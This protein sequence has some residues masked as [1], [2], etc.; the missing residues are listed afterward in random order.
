MKRGQ[1]P[2][3]LAPLAH[4]DF[5]LLW[6]G[7]SFSTIGNFVATVALPW[8]VLQLTGSPAQIGIVVAIS[9]ATNVALLLLGGAVVDRLPRRR[10]LLVSDFLSALVFGVIG[11]LGQLG[12]LRIEHIYIATAISAA[13]A[14]FFTPAITALLPDL[15]PSD[16]LVA[17]NSLR[18][19]SR[20][21]GRMLGPALGGLL[22]AL[23]GL[24]AAFGF[25]AL[26]FC[27]SFLAVLATHPTDDRARPHT[28]L[29]REVRT[30]VAFVFAHGWIWVTIALAS[31]LNTFLIAATSVALP[32]ELREVL[33]VDAAAFGLV[34]AAQG[35]GEAAGALITN[36][37]RVQHVG[38][39]MYVW[40]AVLGLA[41]LA[42][43][44]PL[45]SVIVVASVVYGVG[46]VSFGILWETSLQRRV[47]R[48][49]LGRV[50]SVD[51]FGSLIFAPIGPLA[52]GALATTYGP[53]PAFIIAG[54][55]TVAALPI[56]VSIRSIREL[57]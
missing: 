21:V 16:V 23:G 34:F 39:A 5:A 3:L 6:S 12:L 31:V 55:L 36:R 49:L 32:V 19:I 4:R 53:Q 28:A 45:L 46:L 57:R 54:L 2:S 9:L 47:P 44:I 10:I 42:Y 18:G 48:E 30:G 11:L 37:I 17:G 26:T 24:P 33:H 56:G 41:T 15:V 43:A 22:V 50:A 25:D 38:I 1:L 52:A 20:Q 13:M 8:Q 14:A 27:V 40:I 7:Q 29:W 51:G 35:V